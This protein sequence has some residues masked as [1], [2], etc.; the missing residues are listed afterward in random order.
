[1]NT[2][3]GVAPSASGWLSQMT[4]SEMRYLSIE[5][6]YK[7]SRITCLHHN[8]ERLSVNRTHSLMRS[9]VPSLM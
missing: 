6:E 5:L 2:C 1:M 7:L 8:L 9:H 3:T 4:R